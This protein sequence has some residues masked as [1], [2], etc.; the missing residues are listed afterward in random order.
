M[1]TLM[2]KILCWINYYKNKNNPLRK[3]LSPEGFGVVC[4]IEDKWWYI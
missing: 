2:G 1:E 3:H 4:G